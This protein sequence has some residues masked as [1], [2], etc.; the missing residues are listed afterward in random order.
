MF[1]ADLAKYLVV[2][3]SYEVVQGEL[4][5]RPFDMKPKTLG[6][7]TYAFDITRTHSHVGTHIEAPWHYYGSGKTITDFPVQFSNFRD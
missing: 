3:L 2:D 7:G 4:E 1:G 5:D 6:D